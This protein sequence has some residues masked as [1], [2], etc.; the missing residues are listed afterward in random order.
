[1]TPKKED[2]SKISIELFA[3]PN[4]QFNKPNALNLNQKRDVEQ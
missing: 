1:M 3:Y 4:T 2:L